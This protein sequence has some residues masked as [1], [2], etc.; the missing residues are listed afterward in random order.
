MTTQARGHKQ[1]IASLET[2]QSSALVHSGQCEHTAARAHAVLA[3]LQHARQVNTLWCFA[4]MHWFDWSATVDADWSQAMSTEPFA[5]RRRPRR[6][7]SDDSDKAED[8]PICT[9]PVDA[10]ASISAPPSIQHTPEVNEERRVGLLCDLT[11]L[12]RVDAA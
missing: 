5:L 12:F 10:R 9:E 8:E 11:A 6:R 4:Q 7:D 3:V 1:A 2:K